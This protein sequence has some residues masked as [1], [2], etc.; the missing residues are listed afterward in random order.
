MAKRCFQPIWSN[1]SANAIG[2]VGPVSSAS[3]NS[4]VEGVPLGGGSDDQPRRYDP[5][6]RTGHQTKR[7]HHESAGLPTKSRQKASLVVLDARNP[8]EAIRLRLERP[9]VMAKGKMI[10][11]RDR[12]DTQM[13]LPSRMN[14]R[15]KTIV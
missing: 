9:L 13:T 11:R 10:A 2:I 5:L 8:R 6:L 3:L 4:P 1:A 12:Q 15:H 7:S 14:S